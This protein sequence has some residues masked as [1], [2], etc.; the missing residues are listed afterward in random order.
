[1]T[2]LCHMSTNYCARRER[3]RGPHP[4]E[5]MIAP[6]AQGL[7]LSLDERDHLFRFAGHR[8]PVRGGARETLRQMP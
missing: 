8:P 7:H 1:M 3:E 6:I 4:S 2:K 5:Q